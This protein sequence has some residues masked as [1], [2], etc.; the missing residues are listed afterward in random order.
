[1]RP[2]AAF[3]REPCSPDPGRPPGHGGP[4][5]DLLAATLGPMVPPRLVAAGPGD[6][7]PV[8][9]GLLDIAAGHPDICCDITPTP[10]TLR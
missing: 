5:S 4:G 9:S 2:C 8:T 10:F 1:M 3:P 7:P 6:R